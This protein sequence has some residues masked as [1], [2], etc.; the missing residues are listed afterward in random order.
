[1]L[2][3]VVH[4]MHISEPLRR[5]ECWRWLHDVGQ[6]IRYTCRTLKRN[7]GFGAAIVVTLALGVGANTA[8]FSVVNAVLL[9]PLPYPDPNE[10]VVL[11]NTI[12][13]RPVDG[14]AVSAPKFTIWRQSSTTV[15]DI[16][17]YTFGRSLDVTN[18]DDPQPI[19][20]SRVSADFFRLFGAS[21]AQG[22]TFTDAEARWGGDHVA[23]V[24]DRFWRSRLGGAT[25][26]IGQTLSLDSD[27]F[28]IGAWSF[29]HSSTFRIWAPFKEGERVP[30][31]IRR[32]KSP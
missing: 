21:V 23:I 6:D 13:G 9:K 3:R 11:V 14:L 10:I 5:V 24:S 8:V 2:S 32:T 18:P 20:V 7:P 1:M 19:P 31:A 4:V 17:A 26:V 25:G 12:H 28:T 15:G 29:S 16:A 27:R 22:R 30:S